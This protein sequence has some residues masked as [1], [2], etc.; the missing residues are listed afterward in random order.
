MASKNKRRCHQVTLS[1]V[2]AALG[3]CTAFQSQTSVSPLSIRAPLQTQP[4]KSNSVYGRFFEGSPAPE[5]FTLHAVPELQDSLHTVQDIL[6]NAP[7]LEKSLSLVESSNQLNDLLS[8]YSSAAFSTLLM[9]DNPI[10]DFRDGIR[11]FQP[12]SGVREGLTGIAI[13]APRIYTLFLLTSLAATAKAIFQ[14]VQSIKDGVKKGEL[15]KELP[16]TSILF[17]RTLPIW[18]K[19]FLCIV[20]DAIGSSSF[21]LPGLGELTDLIWA[22]IAAL[23]LKGMFGSNILSGLIAM[24]E[25]LP[26][27]DFLPTATLAFLL[28]ATPVGPVLGLVPMFSNDEKVQNRPEY[29]AFRSKEGNSSQ[30]K[31]SSAEYEDILKEMKKRNEARNVVDVEVVQDKMKGLPNKD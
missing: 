13:W 14:T 24:E 30:F 2:L 1:V 11:D 28:S 16:M 12:F 6:N 26:F 21:L 22:P 15:P 23:I 20:V 29:E 18:V 9:A 10:Q 31:G 27:A 5:H 19:F 4:Q 8:S 3:V 17:L 7:D 25:L